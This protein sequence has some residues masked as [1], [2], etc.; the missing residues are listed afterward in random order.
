MSSINAYCW[1]FRGYAPGTS[2]Q[3]SSSPPPSPTLFS[4]RWQTT[5]FSG[6]TENRCPSTWSLSILDVLF[7]VILPFIGGKVRTGRLQ[8]KFYFNLNGL[9][10]QCWV[11]FPNVW[12]IWITGGTGV[13]RSG[14]GKRN[15]M[16]E[17]ELHSAEVRSLPASLTTLSS[18]DY[19]F[20]L[21][22]HGSQNPPFPTGFKIH[23]VLDP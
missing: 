10:G 2:L 19:Q 3:K 16:P 5:W 21:M 1:N 9:R 13:A 18:V 8:I 20:L 11:M 14:P 4:P 6:T 23:P 22:V 12:P 15:N 7:S 17:G